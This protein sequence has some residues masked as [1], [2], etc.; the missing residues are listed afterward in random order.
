MTYDAADWMTSCNQSDVRIS[1]KVLICHWGAIVKKL[2]TGWKFIFRVKCWLVHLSTIVLYKKNF[3]R[4]N[5]TKTIHLYNCFCRILSQSF[6][7]DFFIHFFKY[8]FDADYIWFFFIFI[9]DLLL[10]IAKYFVRNDT[11]IFLFIFFICG[12]SLFS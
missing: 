8:L 7:P 2:S 5:K 11:I 9:Y 6:D 10:F 3:L 4:Y 1:Q 12:F